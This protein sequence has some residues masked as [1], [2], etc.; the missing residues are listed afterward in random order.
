MRLVQ[1]IG[2]GGLLTIPPDY[3]GYA[4]VALG[5]LIFAV[6]VVGGLLAS[7]GKYQRGRGKRRR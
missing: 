1:L 2:V 3:G 5:L 7:D 4:I 6:T